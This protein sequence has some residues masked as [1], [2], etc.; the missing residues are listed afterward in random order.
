MKR[1]ALSLAVVALL[2][3]PA[4]PCR[5][6]LVVSAH[7]VPAVVDFDS[8]VT[9]VNNG[10]YLGTGFTP[11]PAAGQLDSDSWAATGF[12]DPNMNFGDTRTTGDYARGASA[13]A[14]TT[15]GIYSFTVGAS[16]NALGVQPGGSD[17]T[18]GTIT[19]RVQN[20]TGVYVDGWSIS[21][22]VYV[23]NDQ[24]R[25]NSFN[26][27]YSTDNVNYTPAPTLDLI[28]PEAAGV[29]TFVVNS[30][31]LPLF[32]APVNA[33]ANLYLRWTGDDVSGGGSRDEFALDDISVSAVVPEASA[34]LFGG[35]ACGL[36]ACGLRT[37]RRI[38]RC[39]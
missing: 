9:G 22:N 21:Y 7:G 33:G 11:A 34:F 15:G 8:T 26:F 39:I 27:S 25:A 31:S 37:G 3:W 4:L 10:A 38:A 30:R 1:A 12:D 16:N 5:G 19:L 23:R 18:P 28:S 14:V 35:V 6:D 29:T 20:G 13:A 17:F 36:A 24:A 2:S 32:T